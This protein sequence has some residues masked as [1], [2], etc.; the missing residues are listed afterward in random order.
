[1]V[2][3][4]IASLL[5]GFLAAFSAQSEPAFAQA[6][7]FEGARVIPGDGS[8]AIED[9]GILVEG[10]TIARIGKKQDIAAPAGAKRVEFA[11][12][13][14]MPALISAHVHPGFQRGLTYSAENFRRETI[15]DD[16][17]RALYFGVSTVMSQ[18]IETGDVMF[19]IRAEQAA[20]RIG[21]ARLLLAGRG[22]GAP[23]AGP[24]NPIYAHFAYAITTEAEGKAAVA[25]QAGRGVDAIK[26]WIDDRGGRAPRLTIPVARIIIQE[27]H[28]RGLKVAAH[29]FYH[30]DAVALAEAGIDGFMHLVRDQEMSDALVALMVKKNIYLTPTLAAPERSTHAGVPAWF[31]EP[32][33]AQLLQDTVSADVITRM[34]ASFTGRDPALTA[35]RQAEYAVLKR[36][37]AK[38]SA[39][40]ARVMLGPDTGLEDNF[41]GYAEQKELQLMVEAGMKPAQVIVAATSAP[42]QYLGL[43]DRGILAAGKRADF[44][45][46]DANPLEDIGNTRRIARMYLAGNEVDR[47]AIKASLMASAKK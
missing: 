40:G 7:L 43:T 41:F 18:G 36:S 44:L 32:Y 33:L 28:A 10:S 1:M 6:V 20:G 45:V 3:V 47:E 24:G 27:A 21:G 15:L 13:T 25:E 31:E 26:I 8:P 34:R 38:L 17:N 16:L 35:R 37:L 29:I 30:E 12:K 39:A 19:R 11:G 5:L 2:R 9:A 4:A 23:N 42:A 14:I 46:L 22:I